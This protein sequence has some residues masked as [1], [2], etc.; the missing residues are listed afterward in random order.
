MGLVPGSKAAFPG[1]RIWVYG[2]EHNTGGVDKDA[3]EERAGLD[4]V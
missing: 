3:E 1:T 2:W 4:R